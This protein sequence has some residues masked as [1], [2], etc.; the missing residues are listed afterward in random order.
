MAIENKRFYRI[1]PLSA[2]EKDLKQK[3]TGYSKLRANIVSIRI[4]FFIAE[5]KDFIN[6]AAR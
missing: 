6:F 5:N 2:C 4:I 1:R 3:Q